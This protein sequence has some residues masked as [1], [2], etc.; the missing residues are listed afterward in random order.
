[1]SKPEG[2]VIAALAAVAVVLAGCGGGGSSPTPP[3]GP[4]TPAPTPGPTPAPTPAPSTGFKCESDITYDDGLVRLEDK[5]IVLDDTT[6]LDCSSEILGV[7]PNTMRNIKMIRTNAPWRSFWPGGYDDPTQREKRLGN[8]VKL[9]KDNGMKVLLGQDATCDEADDDKQWEINLKLIKELGEDHIMGI[10]IGNEMDILWTHP[11]WWREKFPNCM[12]DLWDK[13]KYWKA[14]QR[15]VSAMDEALGSSN[16]PV[17]SVWTAGFSNSGAPGNDPPFMEVPGHALV[18]SFVTSAHKLY[19]KRWIWTFNP[20]PI[21]TE[22]LQPDPGQTDVCNQAIEATKGPIAASMVVLARQ[23]VTRL[24]GSAD[25][26]I[27]GGEIGWSSPVSDGMEWIPGQL[28]I[29]CPN[30]TSVQTFGGYYEHFLKWDLSLKEAPKPE[31]QNLKGLDKA[32]YFTMRDASNGAA[33][34]YFGLIKKCGDKS[35]KIQ[36]SPPLAA[37]PTADRTISV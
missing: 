15:R 16:I 5:G 23:A 17:T 35:C 3:P 27:W 31:D 26:A 12:I 2:V 8:F 9:V 18:R 13:Q 24:T 20:Y 25:E 30:Y 14:F 37:E 11:D 6:F 19:G 22:N 10:A 32:F 29:K 33:A 4:Q 28:P 1:M 34:E 21:W 36:A 7:W